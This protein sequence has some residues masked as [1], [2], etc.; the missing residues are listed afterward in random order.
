MLFMYKS[1]DMIS[2]L[3]CFYSLFRHMR[4]DM[5]ISHAFGVIAYFYLVL[6]I[7]CVNEY[8]GRCVSILSRASQFIGIGTTNDADVTP[9]SYAANVELTGLEVGDSSPLYENFTTNALTI[10]SL[11]TEL[12]SCFRGR[13]TEPHS[14]ITSITLTGRQTVLQSGLEVLRPKGPEV[15]NSS[16]DTEIEEDLVAD[17]V[18]SYPVVEDEECGRR[19]D[20][21]CGY[22]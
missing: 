6:R 21:A 13:T 8:D 18:L 12:S 4:W 14:A 9:L 17:F 19:D 20:V 1:I 16:L 7:S 2:A 11:T 22:V 3:F 10:V 15:L 5:C